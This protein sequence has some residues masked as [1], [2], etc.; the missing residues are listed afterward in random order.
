VGTA[1]DLCY[2]ASKTHLRKAFAVEQDLLAAEIHASD[3]AALHLLRRSFVQ[4]GHILNRCDK[5]KDL[6]ATLYSRLRHLDDLAPLTHRFSQVLSPPYVTSWHPLPDLP[7]AA[8]VRTLIEH[9]AWVEGCAISPDGSFIAS[10]SGD[11]TLKVWGAKSGDCL[12]TL[13]LHTGEQLNDCACF[14]DGQQIVAAGNVGVYFLRL[15]L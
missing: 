3:D 4:S 5:L 8:L 12:A 2:L 10:A 6:M 15:E 14:T 7:H 9:T 1:K 13:Y 11:G